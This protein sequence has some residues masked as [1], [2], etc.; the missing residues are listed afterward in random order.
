MPLE[1]IM[2]RNEIGLKRMNIK[3][4]SIIKIR[5]DGDACRIFNVEYCYDEELELKKMSINR[6]F[7][8]KNL[9]KWYVHEHM[10][11][12]VM[13][14]ELEIKKEH[15]SLIL[16]ISMLRVFIFQTYSTY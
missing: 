12:I 7:I 1:H 10:L 2:L 15:D 11:N 8:F 5:R 6:L 4:S 3:H 13:K 14:M 16:M 9:R